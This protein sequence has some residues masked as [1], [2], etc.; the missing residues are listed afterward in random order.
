MAVDINKLNT[1]RTRTDRNFDK[2]KLLTGVELIEIFQDIEKVANDGG[3]GGGGSQTLAQTLVLGNETDG[4]N[5]KV[6]NAD[7]IELENTSLLKKGTYNF[8]AT[9][10]ISRICSN[11]YE[12]NWQDGFRHVF[13]QSGFIRNSTNCFDIVPN[14]S[15]DETLR[16]KVGSF[17]TLDNGTTYI[18]RDATIGA[19]VWEIYS[20]YEEL[21]LADYKAKAQDG[22]L[23]KG[24]LYAITNIIFTAG[25][26][27]TLLVQ[28]SNLNG[29][30]ITSGRLVSNDFGDNIPYASWEV[31]YN[32]NLEAF[33]S[34]YNQS[35]DIR[36]TSYTMFNI[37]FASS[38]V[39]AAFIANKIISC[40]FSNYTGTL[41]FDGYGLTTLRNCDFSNSSADFSTDILNV[42]S[43]A[44]FSGRILHDFEV[45]NQTL[46]PCDFTNTIHINADGTNNMMATITL[47]NSQFRLDFTGFESASIILL[48]PD[49]GGNTI[50]SI[51]NSVIGRE[52]TIISNDTTGSLN[53]GTGLNVLIADS[54]NLF[55]MGL[56]SWGAANSVFNKVYFTYDGI[57]ALINNKTSTYS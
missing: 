36:C 10:G 43:G 34:F 1:A 17:W 24:K 32:F 5:I 41:I 56:I 14:Y 30:Y 21:T 29:L 50:D 23:V 55:Y 52:Y 8:G 57:N 47:T 44:T 15:F 51:I 40:D 54:I 27:W 53:I 46:Y 25:F 13:D 20:L 42:V 9:G 45:P 31:S 33:T 12:D 2:S 7:A 22:D 11:N 38:T 6:N 39:F 37:L 49:V 26:S 48:V 3:G 19:A 18:C 16:F 28:A 35:L 4:T